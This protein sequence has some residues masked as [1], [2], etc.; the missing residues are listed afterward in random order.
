MPAATS[1]KE[2][3]AACEKEYDLLQA[4]LEPVDDKLAMKTYEDETSIRDVIVHRAHWIDLFLKW[5]ADGEAGRTVHIPAKGYK[6]SELKAY[7]AK[8][9]EDTASVSWRAAKNRLK[10]G[11]AKLMAFLESHS[12]AELYGKPMTG[13][14]KWT[15]GR[16][17]EASGS[18]HYRS[19]TKFV[20]SVQRKHKG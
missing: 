8:V 4:C 12:D 18:S 14:D 2:L 10:R 17:A 11:H 5:Y 1:K 7:N 16:F 15:T 19:A 20:R 6:W 9:R 3:I 13:H